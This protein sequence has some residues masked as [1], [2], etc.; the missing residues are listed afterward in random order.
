MYIEGLNIYMAI[1]TNINVAIGNID[2]MYVPKYNLPPQKT[3]FFIDVLSNRNSAKFK[4][5]CLL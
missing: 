2:I 1:A 4:S 5:K 3:F